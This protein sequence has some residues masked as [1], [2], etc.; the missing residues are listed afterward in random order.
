M[1]LQGPIPIH[2]GQLF[3][4]GCYA[5]GEV[6]KVRDFDASTPDRFV[7]SRDKQ[8]GEPVWQLAVM[9]PDPAAKAAQKTVVV[10]LVGQVEPV[11]PPPTGGLPFTPVEFEALCVTPYVN[12]DG[13]L[14]YSIKARA[15]RP[16]RLHAKPVTEPK[17]AA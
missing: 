1:A 7:Q 17:E 6:E 8:T 2:F 10:K 5:V 16:I 15:V 11:V 4:H 12:K 9:D 14:A 3:P 13:R